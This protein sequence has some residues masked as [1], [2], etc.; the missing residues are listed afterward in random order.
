M[1]TILSFFFCFLAHT[2]HIAH[3]PPHTSDSHS[4]MPES[5]T[6][7][8][9][10]GQKIK[11]VPSS[12]HSVMP[13]PRK[14]PQN[15]IFINVSMR[16]LLCVRSVSRIILTFWSTCL[17]AHLTL[18]MLCILIYWKYLFCVCVCVIILWRYYESTAMF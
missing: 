12:S 18:H 9:L 5:H 2:G 3:L 10:M 17:N 11:N 13:C 4:G 16:M 8:A 1:D 15:S 6:L 14:K 7:S